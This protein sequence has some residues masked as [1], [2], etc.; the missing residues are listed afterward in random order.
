M[1]AP[2]GRLVWHHLVVAASF[3]V[4]IPA[5]C[6]LIPPGTVVGTYSCNDEHRGGHYLYVLKD[7]GTFLSGHDSPGANVS[8]GRWTQDCAP[9]I[10]LE[11]PP[12]ADPNGRIVD[13]GGPVLA[14]VGDEGR[15]ITA[16]GCVFR[17]T[18]LTT[19]VLDQRRRFPSGRE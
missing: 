8:E 15:E 7:D 11:R 13:F 1:R 12:V 19:G 14:E 17:R 4:L 10:T 6:D 16:E 3:A 18:A 5:C 2:T 9:R